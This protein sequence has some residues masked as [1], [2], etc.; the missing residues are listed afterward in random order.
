VTPLGVCSKA[1][2]DQVRS[3]AF[4]ALEELCER[5]PACTLEDARRIGNG[6]TDSLDDLKK[7][8]SDGLFPFH[9]LRLPGIFSF[10]FGAKFRSAM[11]SHAFW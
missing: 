9:A 6:F 2:G 8:E 1:N 3:Q 5:D 7:V 11:M 4:R 10:V